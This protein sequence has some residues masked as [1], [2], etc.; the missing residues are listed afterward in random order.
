M[1]I[2]NPECNPQIIGK[3]RQREG[4]GAAENACRIRLR[5]HCTIVPYFIVCSEGGTSKAP[6][7]EALTKQIQHVP[8]Q[9]KSMVYSNGSLSLDRRVRRG[10]PNVLGT[11]AGFPLPAC[12]G[13]T[14]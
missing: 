9:K 2:V 11:P 1:H 3:I 12:V 4:S 13:I 8:A 10:F 6:H 14:T 5:S 7:Q